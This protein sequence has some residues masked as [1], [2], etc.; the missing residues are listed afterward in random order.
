MVT[1]VCEFKE[2]VQEEEPVSTFAM[3]DLPSHKIKKYDRQLRLWGDHGQAALE[4]AKIC[5]IGATASGT[6]VLKNLVLPGVGY[7]CIVDSDKV[8]ASDLGS[9]FFVTAQSL[10]QPRAEVVT[11]LLL[12]MN[13]DVKGDYVVDSLDSLLTHRASWL[14][15]FSVIIVADH[16]SEFQLICLSNVLWNSGIPL[17]ICRYGLL[18]NFSTSKSTCKFKW[19]FESP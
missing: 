17:V 9:N 5:L 12:E 1:Q 6:E 7:F 4:G 14:R 16:S 8:V 2:T 11:K 18:V 13:T 19:I 10:G 3:N 15:S